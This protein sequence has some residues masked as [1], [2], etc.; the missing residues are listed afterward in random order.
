MTT[1][2]RAS[3]GTVSLPL[4]T[5]G[6]PMSGTIVSDFAQAVGCLE[7]WPRSYLCL[8]QQDIP[9]PSSVGGAMLFCCGLVLVSKSGHQ[10]NVS[11]YAK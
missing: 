8:F 1:T 7:C 6:T 2:L 10:Q 4:E 11:R 3:V 5:L 9:I